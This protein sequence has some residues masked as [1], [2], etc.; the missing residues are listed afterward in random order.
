MAEQVFKPSTYR[1]WFIDK[2]LRE[3]TYPTTA[4]LARD[5]KKEFGKKINP[6]SIAADIAEMREELKAPIKYDAEKRGFFY[7]NPDY[8]LDFI[9]DEL[10][11]LPDIAASLGMAAVEPFAALSAPVLSI[12]A[13]MVL[14]SAWRKN[15]LSGRVSVFPETARDEPDK[16]GRAIKDA[17]TD[18]RELSIGYQ[19]AAGRNLTCIVRPLHLVYHKNTC[20][21]L[22]A[23]AAGSAVPHLLL[24]MPRIQ[25]AA[26][27]G[28]SFPPPRYVHIRIGGNDEIE[29]ILSDEQHDTLL[30]FSAVNSAGDALTEYALLS[31]TDMYAPAPN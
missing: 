30:V 20:L 14:A 3:K 18:C 23:A 7:T 16:T 28:A 22:A 4:S 12:L 10:M 29:V 2:K 17:L 1:K 26:M 6:R 27:T 19:S 8:T 21:L 15:P 9:K 25:T 31:K 13:S 5:Y 11:T 24:P